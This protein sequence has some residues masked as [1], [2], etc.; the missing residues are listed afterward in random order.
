M[1][2]LEVSQGMTVAD[3]GAG[4][5]FYVLEA[6]RRVGGDGHVYAIDV[7]KILLDRIKHSAMR[8]GCTNVDVIWGDIE[9]IG[10]TKLKDSMIDRVVASNVFFQIE[11]KDDFC[12]EIK[13]ILKPNGKVMII[14]W[15]EVSQ[16]GPKNIVTREVAK[17]HFEKA[18]LKFVLDFNAGDHHYGFIFQKI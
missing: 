4:S 9:K 1:E 15:S 2:K 16:I 14:D 7:Q 5:G 13:R 3:L 18:G 17:L 11:H 6:A 8:I 10:G 12:L